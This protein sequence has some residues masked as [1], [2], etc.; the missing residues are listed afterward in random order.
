MSKVE[1]HNLTY[2]MTLGIVIMNIRLSEVKMM[3]I[4]PY[5]GKRKQVTKVKF[6]VEEPNMSVISTGV[7]GIS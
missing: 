4:L 6:L 7:N 3:T 2:D 1:T 5:F